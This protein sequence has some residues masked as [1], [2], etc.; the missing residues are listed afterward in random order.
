MGRYVAKLAED[1]Y[2]EWSTVVDAPVTYIVTRTEAVDAWGQERVDR[3]DQKGTSI[4]DGYPAGKTPEEIV[5]GNHAGPDET[6][7]TVQEIISAYDAK[8]PA[9]WTVGH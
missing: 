9:A 7:L 2:V 8:D 1:T 5:L 4:L 3:A 6:E